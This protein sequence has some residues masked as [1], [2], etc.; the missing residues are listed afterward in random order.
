MRFHPGWHAFGLC[1]ALAAGPFPARASDHRGS[2]WAGTVPVPGVVV[3]VTRGE[4]QFRTITDFEGVYSVTG[5]E[6]GVWTV[7]LEMPG[8]VRMERD[9]EVGPYGE[10]ATWELEALSID[11][12]TME[13]PGFDA[14]PES[15]DGSRLADRALPRDRFTSRLDDPASEALL[16]NGS[17]NDGGRFE[18][19]NNRRRGLALYTADIDIAANSSALDARSFSLTGQNTPEPAYNRA[20]V[21]VSLSG[22]LWL[23]FSDHAGPAF[24]L[25]YGRGQHQDVSLHTARVPTPAERSG[26]FSHR[27]EVLVDPET[28]SPF[29]GNV[30]PP[31]RISSQ[32]AALVDFYPLPDSTADTGYNYQVQTLGVSHRD[33]LQFQTG[34]RIAGNRLSGSFGLQSSR[35]D[36]RNLF[37]FVDR[38]GASTVSA[39]LGWSRLLTPNFSV[40]AQYT[41]T[42]RAARTTPYFADRVNVSGDAG[43]NGNGQDP[44]DWGP[45]NLN[46]SGGIAGLSDGRS[47][48]DRTRS[49]AVSYSSTWTQNAHAWTFGAGVRREQ[50]NVLS[51]ENARGAFTFTG[52]AS[53]IDFGDFLLGIP[54]TSSI[55]LGN[56]DKYFRQ[57]VYDV[58]VMDDWRVT[59]GLTI[60]F[61]V[62][63]DYESPVTEKYGRLV[64]LEIAPGFRAVAPVLGDHPEGP[65]TGQAYP[66]SLV[67]SDKT[68][69]QPR[70]GAA[71]RP[72]AG[73]SLV[74]RVGYGIYRDGGVYQSIAGEMAQQSPLSTSLSVEN[75]PSTPLTL[76]DGFGVAP[77]TTSNTF[78][79]DPDFQTGRTRNWQL[80]I[81]QDLPAGFQVTATYAGVRGEHLPQ[82]ILP[83]TFPRGQVGPCATCPSGYAYLT[84]GGSSHQHAGTV[85]LRRRQQN[86]LG[87]NIQYTW[88]RAIDDAGLGGVHVAQD[89]QDQAAERAL[90]NF[91]R[92]HQVR[93]QTFYTTGTLA[94]P[95]EEWTGWLRTLFREWTLTTEWIVASGSPMTPK[96]IAPAQGTGMTGS[97]RPDRTGEPLYA[98]TGE[99]RLNSAAFSLPAPGAWGNAGRNSVTGPGQFSLDASLGRTFRTSEGL[100][101]DF[102]VD[103]TN[104]LNHVSFADWNTVLDSAQFGWPVRANPMRTVRPSLR[105]RF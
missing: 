12:M 32:A 87:A 45:P 4:I 43:I 65:L 82:R 10:A 19:G 25:L 72:I 9:L 97:L 16:I 75:S 63:W 5:L 7:R 102:R 79:V 85:A 98:G 99:A 94:G 78:A 18:F 93:V 42:R 89:W 57:S 103:V 91:D 38:L 26:D 64:N 62:R 44:R 53:G 80:S 92:R 84:S 100:V 48:F 14:F 83:N 46:F 17:V 34:G 2:V 68:D 88:S 59:P 95:G 33:S 60:N 29:P 8:F 20:D 41:F 56:P 105:V 35:S 69:I 27:S 101:M 96:L 66:A 76:A 74:V 21:M 86:G 81:Q 30:I 104:V 54:T 47:A 61:G 22:P 11:D 31:D 36:N 52:A 67:R 50:T 23:P 15:V 77:P 6:D 13:T 49:G 40:F 1:L 70:I 3:Q 71:W 51:Q 73:V 24:T 37:A 55:A 90:S 28:A 58:Y 39:S